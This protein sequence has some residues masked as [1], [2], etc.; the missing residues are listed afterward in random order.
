MMGIQQT[1]LVCNRLV[2]GCEVRSWHEMCVPPLSIPGNERR[3]QE[4]AVQ[5]LEVCLVLQMGIGLLT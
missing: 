5:L 4:V 1:H 3:M 2:R